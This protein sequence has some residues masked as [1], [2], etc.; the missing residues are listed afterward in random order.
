MCYN[1]N[2]FLDNASALKNLNDKIVNLKIDVTTDEED[3][4]LFNNGLVPEFKIRSTFSALFDSNS[5]KENGISL[6]NGKKNQ[7]NELIETPK[8]TINSI[9]TLKKTTRDPML[10]SNFF[11]RGEIKIPSTLLSTSTLSSTTAF[12]SLKQPPKQENDYTAKCIN[13]RIF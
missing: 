3:N 10:S 8:L 2:C 13:E 12:K 11:N 9:D 1:N 4:Q 5:T 6:E 7:R